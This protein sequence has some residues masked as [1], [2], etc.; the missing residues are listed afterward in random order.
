MPEKA[1]TWRWKKPD[2]SYE[3]APAHATKGLTRQK[4]QRRT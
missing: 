3:A 1:E 4:V 2:A